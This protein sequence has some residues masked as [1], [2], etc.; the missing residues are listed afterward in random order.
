MKTPEGATVS[1][2]TED[3]PAAKAGLKAGDV[4]VAVEDERI[5]KMRELPRQVARL[6]ADQTANFTI[7]ATAAN[8]Y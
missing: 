2:V 4:I 6:A 7:V 3:S 5:E 8:A 1:N